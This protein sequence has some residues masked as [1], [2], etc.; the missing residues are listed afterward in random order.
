MAFD[1]KSGSPGEMPDEELLVRCRDASDQEIRVAVGILAER[2]HRALT[3]FLYRFVGQGP[4]AEDLAQEAFLR[5][6]R[7]ARHYKEIARFSTWL[8][9]IATNLALNEIRNSKHRPR[10]SLSRSSS[11]RDEGDDQPVVQVAEPGPGPDAVA[12]KRDL[13]RV[14]G[15]LI[16][17]IPEK[18]RVVLVLCDLEA[19]T[20]VEAAQTLGVKVGT[21]RSRL[22]RARSHFQRRAEQRL[23]HVATWGEGRVST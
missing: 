19:M 4:T 9:R 14:V 20:Y 21:I 3:R 23:R 5:V 10:L 15:E 2:H 7:K 8:Y 13:G 1:R 11:G 18:Y 17:E 12:E 22:F 6:Y 16:Q